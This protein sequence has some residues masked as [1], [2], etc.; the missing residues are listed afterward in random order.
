MQPL[1][2]AFYCQQEVGSPFL[3]LV[4][5]GFWVWCNSYGEA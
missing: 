4:A 3:E 5:N 1:L 2:A